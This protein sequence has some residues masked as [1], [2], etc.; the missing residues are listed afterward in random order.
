[1]STPNDAVRG[2]QLP[3]PAHHEIPFGFYGR[4]STEDNQ[5]P[6]SSRRWQLTRADTLISAHGG[7][8]ITEYFDVGQTRALPWKRLPHALRLLDA[9]KDPQR[10]FNDV[11]IGEPHRAF[12]GNQ[13]GLIIPLFQHYKVR[14]WAPEIGG[15]IDPNNEAHELVMNVFGGMSTGE[16]GRIKIR[17]RTA[18]TAQT[19]LEGR[20]LGGRPPYG[21]T[22][23]D[24]GPH[25]N[26]GKAAEGKRL[27]GLTPD[28]SAASVVQR[29]FALF[30]DGYGIFAIAEQ[31]TRDGV[32]CPSAHDPA[33]NRHRSGIAWSKTAVRT[34][35]INPR[36]TG[37][38]IWN[39]QYNDEVLLDVEDVAAGHTTVTRWNTRDAWVRSHTP[40]HDAIIDEETFDTAQALLTR[41]GDRL[42]G[43]RKQYR[44]RHPYVFRG[45]VYCAACGR[46]MQ[47]QYSH[48][49]AY[50]R[51]RFPQEYAIA[52]VLDH[53]RN[54]YVREDAII[55]PLDQWLATAFDPIG[56][57]R[58][59]EAMAEA[60]DDAPDTSA[61]RLA[62]QACDAK[63][64]QYRAALDAGA[65][66]VL[67]ASWIRQTQQERDHAARTLQPSRTAPQSRPMTIREVTDLVN[68]LGNLIDVLTEAAP[69]DKAEV[70][71][72]LGVRLTFHPDTQTA[73]AQL[74]LGMHRGE[75]V[76]VEGGN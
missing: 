27:H 20:Y 60:S 53:P 67:V 49:A 51:C 73:H 72:R 37:Y 24:L 58:T 66:P 16:R 5:D 30:L 22:L 54:V 63:L 55:P 43:P 47:G 45:T 8:I 15:P 7:R 39:K 21:Y 34:I 17:V 2:A 3:L 31:L 41:R 29:I 35:L 68:S 1:M 18:M 71:R 69:E 9:L 48:G 76:C 57:R 50:Y 11:V 44:S 32:P 74:D 64:N 6:T 70:Y 59:I 46:K 62:V 75:K 56:R 13:L 4:V 52:N 36:Y 26:P 19:A 10:G 14:L 42:G 38:Q 40:S 23:Q 25:P 33:R 61:A 28:P 12:Y 65:D